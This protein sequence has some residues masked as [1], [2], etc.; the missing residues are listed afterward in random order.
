METNITDITPAGGRA[1]FG[2]VSPWNIVPLNYFNSDYAF[3]ID[4][5]IQETIRGMR[6]SILAM[7]LGLAKIRE[8]G[9]F[10][11]LGCK[12]IT[13]YIE[14]LANENQMKSDTIFKWLRI[15]EAYIKY[16]SDLE[17]VGFTDSDGPHKL[18]CLESALA[19]K[20]KQEVFSNIKTMSV[21]E[22]ASYAK[23]AKES[24]IDD[25][26]YTRWVVTEKGNTFYVNDKLAIIISSKMNRKAADYFKLVIRTI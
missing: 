3:E 15:G 12:N 19:V 9:L 22:F 13:A 16:Q 23:A 25:D 14:R 21:R 8:K 26:D 6:F 4:K 10:K 24:S 11:N 18:S 1:V 5:G 7:G 17:Q 20:E 2:N